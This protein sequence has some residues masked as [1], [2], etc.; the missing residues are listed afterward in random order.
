M[1]FQTIGEFIEMLVSNPDEA[2]IREGGT[3][4][5]VY[6]TERDAVLLIKG[7]FVGLPEEVAWELRTA[8]AQQHPLKEEEAA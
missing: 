3:E 1:V 5:V 4:A 6:N 7:D 8:I 2:F